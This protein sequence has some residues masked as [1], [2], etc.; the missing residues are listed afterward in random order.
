MSGVR[1]ARMR[2]RI[3]DAVAAALA[4]GEGTL[5]ASIDAADVVSFDLFD[6]LLQRRLPG[7]VIEADGL[8]RAAHADARI[9]SPEACIGMWRTWRT[10]ARRAGQA[11]PGWEAWIRTWADAQGHEAAS[12]LASVEAGMLAAEQ[13]ATVRRERELALVE[14]ARACRKTVVVISDTA[15]PARVL[16]ALLA[17]H[18]VEVSRVFASSEL[19]RTKR[20]GELFDFVRRELTCPAARCVHVGDQL[21]GDCV[22]PRQRGWAAHVLVRGRAD[23]TLLEPGRLALAGVP[24]A[25][26]DPV[27]RF[28]REALAP[29][30]MAFA[31]AARTQLAAHGTQHAWYLARDSAWLLRADEALD[32]V[33]PAPWSRQYL[34]LSRRAVVLAHPD[35]LLGELKGVTGKAG[36][37]SVGEWL[38]G[39][40][41]PEEVVE[42][43]LRSSA[44]VRTSSFDEAARAA[45]RRALG[46]RRDVFDGLRT[47][48]RDLLHDWLAQHHP[49]GS[50][51]GRVALLDVGWA[52]TIQDAVASALGDAVGVAGVYLG[53]TRGARAPS[54]RAPKFGLAWDAWAGPAPSPLD[55]SAG[56]IRAW[57]TLLH[58]PGPS[59]RGLAR[60]DA[61]VVHAID[62]PSTDEGEPAELAARL[63]AGLEPAL[64]EL[65]HAVGA[66]HA[67]CL[68]AGQPGLG[69]AMFGEAARRALRAQMG[70]VVF[71]PPRE[72]ARAVLSL[73]FDEGASEGLTSGLGA[74]NW[75]RGTVWWPGVLRQGLFAPRHSSS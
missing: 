39:F 24:C 17:Y 62:G 6:T 4:P 55:R 13:A 73:R 68:R 32:R 61:G 46:E 26:V 38:N 16:D 41:L 36:R 72:V 53:L 59:V 63:A 47:E 44:L 14:Y 56:V 20:S 74:S 34:R 51:P 11:E 19:G 1:G 67:A 33:A 58:A 66:W 18:G 8:R 65:A 27:E 5:R 75:R 70:G 60:D 43:V 37:A 49:E 12:L 48:A 40:P 31:V 64:D 21:K 9:G 69:S 71:T 25:A 15:H 50:V 35:D 54:S 42:E 28:A 57:E 45:L 29:V 52:G 2:Q 7:D 22:R 23:E 3:A 10:E 30:V